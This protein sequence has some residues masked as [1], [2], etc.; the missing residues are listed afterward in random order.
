MPPRTS[1]RAPRNIGQPSGMSAAATRPATRNDSIATL[2]EL[3]PFGSATYSVEE[4]VA[5]MTAAYLCGVCGIA[6]RTVDNSAAYIAGWP[7]KLRDDRKFIVHAA[8]Q[9]QRA[10]DYVLSAKS[11]G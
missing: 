9:A 4:C 3:A 10:C 6:N 8:A 2:I 11:S 5:E 1:S 7:K